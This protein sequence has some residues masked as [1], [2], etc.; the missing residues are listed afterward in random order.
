[1][2]VKTYELEWDWM[3]QTDQG[4][5]ELVREGNVFK[6]VFRGA[7]GEWGVLSFVP[8]DYDKAMRQ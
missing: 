5:Y 2:K 6:F 7:K 1:M 4:T 8:E 3:K